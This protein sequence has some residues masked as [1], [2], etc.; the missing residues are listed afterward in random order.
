MTWQQSTVA[1][2]G[3]HHRVDGHEMYVARFHHVQKYHE[4]GLAPVVDGS[5]AYHVA[6]NGTAAYS[7]RFL[8]TWGFYEGRA[9]VQDQQGW[10]HILADGRELTRDRF[11]WCGNFQ[12]GRCTVRF[13][14]GQYGHITTDGRVAYEHR[15]LYAGDFR[16]G[17]AVVRYA[18]DGLCGH[19]DE[20]GRP[21]Y[22]PRFLD[23]DVFHKGYARARDERGW[24][25]IR[26]D[27]SAAYERRFNAVEPFYNGQ[28]LVES[29][30]GERLVVSERAEAVLR[31]DRLQGSS[32]HRRILL[33]G[34]IGVG[35]TTLARHL[36]AELTWPV[37]A[38]D[39][40]RQACGDGSAAG[41]VAAW[42]YF[43]RLATTSTNTIIEFS[44]SGAL[45]PLL[46][47]HFLLSRDAVLVFW[48]T[49]SVPTCEARV[50]TRGAHV[51]YPDFGIPIDVVVSELHDRLE[52]EIGLRK[53]WAGFPVHPLD[54]ERPSEAVA[55]EA[56]ETVQA[57]VAQ[58]ES[59]Q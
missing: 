26:V 48:L 21:T 25:H 43:V 45:A 14:G 10:F 36:E 3:T 27:G 18:D 55:S 12:E 46:A 13:L 7:A 17:V 58:L 15:H 35:K 32:P 47:Q 28:A 37:V 39:D 34:N 44:G 16:E 54:G 5:G 9:A 6:A 24:F 42:A 1:P 49:S 30:K 41:E 50:S 59:A 2:D 52:R 4:P 33:I 40:A 8:Q 31:V 11:D 29:L 22:A 19:I 57:W 23:V 53:A 20:S 56:L 38:I 51:P